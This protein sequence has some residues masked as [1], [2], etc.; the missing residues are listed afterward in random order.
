MQSS[1]GLAKDDGAP[2]DLPVIPAVYASY[3]INDRTVVGI[4]AFSN[5]ATGTEYDDDFSAGILA[6]E[7]E[8][9]TININPSIGY[10]LSSNVSVGFGINGVL[11]ESDS[12]LFQP[13]CISFESWRKRTVDPRSANRSRNRRS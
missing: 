11:A 5:F 10:Q 12:F 9:T 2:S 1:T 8:V 3:P 7:S 4:G 13:F 6:K